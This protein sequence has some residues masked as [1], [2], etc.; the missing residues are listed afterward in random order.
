VPL[1]KRIR[2]EIFLPVNKAD[3]AYEVVT[4]WLAE[5]LAIIH[6]GSTLT[7]PF[8]GLYASSS[9][10]LMQDEVRV[11]FCDL[12]LNAA[13][14]EHVGGLDQYLNDLQQTLSEALSEEDLWIVFYPVMRHVREV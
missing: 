7:A 11:L 8:T 6:G 9:G 10:Q 1:E 13:D 3:P 14:S 5:E 2:I 4:R 12:N